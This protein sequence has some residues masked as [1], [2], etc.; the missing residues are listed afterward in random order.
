MQRKR[1]LPSLWHR[2]LTW[3]VGLVFVYM[4]GRYLPIGP[5]PADRGQVAGFDTY[6][7]LALATGGHF[8]MSNLFS[9]GLGPWMTSQILWRFV[10]LSEKAANLTQRQH[11]V[12]QM[13]LMLLVALIQAYGLGRGILVADLQAQGVSSPFLAEFA[14][15]V[16]MVTGSFV[17]FWL[18]TLN[19]QKGIGGMTPLL[20]VNMGLSLLAELPRALTARSL[21]AQEWLIWGSVF[22]IGAVVLLQLTIVTFRA[23]YRIPIRRI[24]ISSSFAKD[25]YLPLKLTPAGGLPFMYAMTLMSLPGFLLS[26]L[27][28]LFPD[29]VF[30]QTLA[31]GVSL[32]TVS[33]LLCYLSLLFLLAI[34]FAY[35]NVNPKEIAEGMQK[36]GDYIE[37]VRP[38]LDTCRYIGGYVRKMAVLG[39]LY[40]TVLG[41][42][43]LVLMWSQSGQL[44]PALLVQT[45]Y[46]VTSLMLSLVEETAVLHIWKQYTDVI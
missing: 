31:E 25:T 15:M 46:M 28:R 26:G 39:A 1:K 24:L 10:S 43:P 45:L 41:G 3:T 22:L 42:F 16:V 36:G 2:K 17:L 23:E 14:P 4:L 37:G 44:G 32:S 27:L 5:L 40:T 38:G 9:L 11:H 35:F 29:A 33:G 18:G 21:S 7:G 34:G 20:L 19:T 8:S 13:G 12:G 6:T 30:L